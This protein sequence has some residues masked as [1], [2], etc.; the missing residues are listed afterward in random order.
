MHR[1][2]M[3][4]IFRP[5]RNCSPFRRRP[6]LR[7]FS[8]IAQPR[9]GYPRLDDIENL[10]QYCP[11]GYHPVS[12]GDAFAGGRYLVVHKLGFGGSST[13]WLA[14]DQHIQEQLGNLV[15][16]KIM[17]A[18]QSSNRSSEIAD[19]YIPQELHKFYVDHPLRETLYVVKD[20]F[21]QK[22]PNGS[23]LCLV[24][25]FSGPSIRS[26]VECDSSGRVSG[27]R[28]FRGDL[29]RRLAKQVAGA[30]EL[31][32]SA[33]IVHGDLTTSNILF[34]VSDEVQK[35]SANYVYQTLGS[36]EMDE[37]QTLDGSPPSPFAPQQCIA[38]IDISL[39]SSP[40]FLKEDVILIDF[41]QSFFANR[42]PPDHTPATVFHY[43]SPEGFFDSEVSFPSDVWA[44]AC[45]IFEIRAG[46]P[47]FDPFLSSRDLILKQVVETLGKF[48]EPWWGEWMARKT[49]FDEAGIPNPVEEDQ[50]GISFP[51]V[52][53][54]VRQKL[55]DIGA[56][57]DNSYMNA[58]AM[59][60]R[61]GTRLGEAEVNL[62]GDLL[63]KMLRYRPED[64]ISIM[65]VVRHPWFAYV[66]EPSSTESKQHLGLGG[67]L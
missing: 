1:I 66:E 37:V 58:G 60:E 57:D 8:A 15:A 18:E 48:P 17:S 61:T 31:M 40:W 59:M 65:E 49:W 3:F 4:S 11:G 43:L 16:L 44:L 41:G 34:Q 20:Y 42:R 24:S 38:P 39:L 28:R 22:G 6:L 33:G 53:T 63:E 10:E 67:C 56:Q 47:L 23:H 55:A 25:Q 9:F 32:H 36:P 2:R 30:V 35:W 13:I 7:T 26:V 54:H 62:L 5:T 50:E 14:Q 29:A 45:A 21:W 64:R 51:V 46:T 27:C 52:K 12:I 19:L